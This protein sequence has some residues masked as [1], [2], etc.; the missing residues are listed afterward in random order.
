HLSR[1]AGRIRP[2][3]S[4]RIVSGARRAG[5]CPSPTK[6]AYGLSPPSTPSPGRGQRLSPPEAIGRLD[7][8]T[9]DDT[10]DSVKGVGDD[11]RPRPTCCT[12]KVGGK[13]GLCRGP[14]TGG[15]TG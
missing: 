13:D 8:S 15:P 1:P 11:T 2:A 4:S 12:L 5:D 10:E 3:P 9:P 14:S 7:Q 6:R